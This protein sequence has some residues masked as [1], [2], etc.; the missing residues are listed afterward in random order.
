MTALASY[1]TGT[2]TITSGGTT[3]TGSTTV[4]S[5]VNVRPGDILQVGNYQTVV[6]DVTDTTHLVIP[7][8]GGGAVSGASYKIFQTSPQRFAGSQAM[9]D[10]S[11]L[12]AALNTNGYFVFVGSTE[13][14]PDP[15]L[16]NDGQ[17][18]FQPSTGIYWLKT[19]GVW[20]LTG[21]PS[22]GVD[23]GTF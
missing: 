14:V 12:V 3:V 8:W 17:W 21:P 16:G 18:A 9:A 22:G 13:T 15:S 10:V 2:V 19:G 11:K 6:S 1:S 7:P 4:W 23:G 5:G 20:V